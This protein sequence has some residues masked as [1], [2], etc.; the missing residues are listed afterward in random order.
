MLKQILT[1]SL[2][3]L[4]VA[5]ATTRVKQVPTQVRA[6]KKVNFFVE[7]KTQA[8]FKVVGMLDDMMM[9]G[10][11]TVKKIGEEDFEVMLLTG[12]LCKVM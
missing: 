2:L 9:D 6:F 3:L 8:G 12:G 1:F 5:C 10:V 11:V 4:L 7:G